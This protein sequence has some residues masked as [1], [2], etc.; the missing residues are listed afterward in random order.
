M[1]QAEQNREHFREGNGMRLDCV[2]LLSSCNG[3]TCTF[4][5][6]IGGI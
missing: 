2:F 1:G 4:E 3:L 5:G 6:E